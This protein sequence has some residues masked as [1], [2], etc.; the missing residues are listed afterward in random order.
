MNIPEHHVLG[1][2]PLILGKQYSPRP[3]CNNTNYESW[4]VVKSIINAYGPTNYWALAKACNRHI[5]G[6]SATTGK[7][8]IDYL[9]QRG[10]LLEENK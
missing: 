6:S 10:Y 4:E 7:A 1:K 2:R 9:L 5:H 8:W 3:K